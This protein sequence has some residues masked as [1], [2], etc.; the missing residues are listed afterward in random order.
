MAAMNARACRESAIA[1]IQ[2]SAIFAPFGDKLTAYDEVH[3]V[4]HIRMLDAETARV[5]WRGGEN[6]FAYR[7]GS[8][9]GDRARRASAVAREIGF[10]NAL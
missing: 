2:T 5:D 7:S 9:Q 10:E 8:G 4:I 6:C 3:A 1:K